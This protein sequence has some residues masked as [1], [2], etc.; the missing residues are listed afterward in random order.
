VEALTRSG[1]GKDGIR[2]SCLGFGDSYNEEILL[3]M[4]GV[5]HGQ[6][7]DADSVDNSR[8]SWLMNW[9]GFRKSRRRTSGSVLSRSFSVMPGHNLAIT[10]PSRFRMAGWRLRSA[11]W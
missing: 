7:H 2:T 6:L 10:R 9:T 8:R 3:A 4:S 1:F 5:G 11:T